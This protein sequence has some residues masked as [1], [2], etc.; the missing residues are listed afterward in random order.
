MVKQFLI[1][2]HPSTYI[3]IDRLW[4]TGDVVQIILPMHNS[5]EHLPNVP[6]YIAFMHG[7][8][9][10]GA[11][12]G[13]EDLEGLVA[14]DSRWGHIAVGKKLP[15]DQAPIIIEDNLSKITDELVPVKDK[16]LTF[17]A[18][19]AKNDQSD[20]CCAGTFLSNS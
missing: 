14:D 4:T 3:A 17:T 11:K 5:I 12:T 13:T 20:K 1:R 9:L 6:S 15:I 18:S 7:P 10:L 16:P 19:K 8:I 2:I